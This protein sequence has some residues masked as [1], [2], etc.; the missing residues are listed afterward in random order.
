MKMN[1]HLAT[2]S[3]VAVGMALAG[4]AY[5]G[6]GAGGG[7]GV[8]ESQANV[9]IA[10]VAAGN[11]NNSSIADNDV[12][13]VDLA[14]A[15]NNLG[16][17]NAS[18]GATADN[19]VIDNKNGKVDIDA[20]DV[21]AEKL[22]YSNTTTVDSNNSALWHVMWNSGN[23]VAYDRSIYN[24]VAQLSH[25]QL[26]S[27]IAKVQMFNLEANGAATGGA[28]AAIAAGEVAAIGIGVAAASADGDSTSGN[29]NFSGSDSAARAA[30]LAGGNEGGDARNQGGN[31][32]AA[33][34]RAANFADGIAI[35][36]GKAT[37]ATSLGDKDGDAAGTS[38]EGGGATGGGGAVGETS[39]TAGAGSNAKSGDA[40]AKAESGPVSNAAT[41]ANGIAADAENTTAAAIGGGRQTTSLAFKFK[42]GSLLEGIT[43]LSGVNP[44][45]QNTGFAQNQNV[46]M[47]VNAIV[48]SVNGGGSIRN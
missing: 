16:A 12:L 46:A 21:D 22:T 38:G 40:T 7:L 11:A 9:G 41:A 33:G 20:L 24:N 43:G 5:A 29:A 1:S 6:G 25:S 27:A 47:S 13:D 30:A 3:V 39:A 45:M 10:G 17:G 37:N 19:D 18:G 15:D 28:G 23:A 8:A 31:S 26:R 48:G 32:R 4:T 2:A 42:T 34:G 35:G 36:G 44:I 14:A